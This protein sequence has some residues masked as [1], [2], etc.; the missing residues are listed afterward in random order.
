MKKLNW[1]FFNRKPDAVA[2]QLLG[3]IIALNGK[4]AKI[5]ETEAYFG[6]QDPAS[7]ASK[8]ENKVS[9]MMREEAGKILVYNVHKYKMLN[10]VCGKKGK[11]GAVLI[12]ACEPLN[13]S[14]RCNGPGLLTLA[15]GVDD[16]L[17]GAKINK[18]GS[19]F[20]YDG[21]LKISD[22]KIGKSRRIGVSED[23][24]EQFRFFIKDNKYVSK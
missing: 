11:A 5:V 7:R 18:R 21:G 19:I 1:K 17:H 22:K 15:L 23:L 8:G 13:F 16:A 10:F 12:R 6:E 14:A 20:V 4:H 24:K 2:R 3:K 9:R